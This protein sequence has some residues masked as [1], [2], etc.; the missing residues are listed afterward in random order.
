LL[1]GA[2]P[3]RKAEAKKTELLQRVR[4]QGLRPIGE[5]VLAQYNPPWTLPL[6]R[7]NE[8]SVELAD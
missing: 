4:G 3:A 2:R 8:V 5:P 6:L 1:G 7:R